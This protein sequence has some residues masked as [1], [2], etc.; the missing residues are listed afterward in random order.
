M[1]KMG[2]ASMEYTVSSQRRE[3][4]ANDQISEFSTLG[5]GGWAGLQGTGYIPVGADPVFKHFSKAQKCAKW[6]ANFNRP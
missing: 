6:D 4:S 3:K 5:Q 1:R 2:L